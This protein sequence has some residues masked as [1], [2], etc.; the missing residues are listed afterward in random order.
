MGDKG[1][2]TILGC[3]AVAV[4]TYELIPLLGGGKEGALLGGRA[5]AG[6]MCGPIHTGRPG[7]SHN[8]SSLIRTSLVTLGSFRSQVHHS[9]LCA[10]G[11]GE[12]RICRRCITQ[13]C[14]GQKEGKESRRQ[15]NGRRC[16][17]QSCV[18]KAGCRKQRRV[19]VLSDHTGPVCLTSPAKSR[20]PAL[21]LLVSLMC[22]WAHSRPVQSIY[23][24]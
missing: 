15:G 6:T 11:G 5:V 10:E 8:V 20:A 19:I 22:Q 17:T 23:R 7:G 12:G 3:R 13:G 14:A 21:H 1:G 24:A 2:P 9:K 16:A 4:T 18:Q